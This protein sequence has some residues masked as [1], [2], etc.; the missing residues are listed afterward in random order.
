MLPAIFMKNAKFLKSLPKIQPKDLFQT[1][2]QQ[3]IGVGIRR[4]ADQ[5]HAAYVGFFF[6]SS[7]LV[8]KLTGHNPTEDISSVKAIEDLSEVETTYPSQRKIQEK[9]DKLAFDNLLGKQSSI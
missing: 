2:K 5:V 8:E 3:K 6:H 1:I 4:S 9:L 7:V